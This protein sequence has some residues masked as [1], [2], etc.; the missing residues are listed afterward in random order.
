MFHVQSR[1]GHFREIAGIPL[2]IFNIVTHV[3]VK[4]TA[5]HSLLARTHFMFTFMQVCK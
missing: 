5:Q 1:S 2:T 4:I 3:C